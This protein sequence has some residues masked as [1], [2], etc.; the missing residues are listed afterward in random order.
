MK[1]KFEVFFFYIKSVYISSYDKEP[2]KAQWKLFLGLVGILK[3]PLLVPGEDN[4]ISVL[5]CFLLDA[6]LNIK[7]CMHHWQNSP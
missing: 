4:C 5:M 1:T 7:I 2:W 3:S 6:L